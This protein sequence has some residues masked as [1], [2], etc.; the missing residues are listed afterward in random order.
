MGGLQAMD[1]GNGVHRLHK[2]PAS[3]AGGDMFMIMNVVVG[4]KVEIGRR[5]SFQENDAPTQN[6]PEHALPLLM[7]ARACDVAGSQK[8]PKACSLRVYFSSILSN[9]KNEADGQ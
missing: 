9:G 7:A 1:P 5:S 6:D 4:V 3:A 2:C 8:R